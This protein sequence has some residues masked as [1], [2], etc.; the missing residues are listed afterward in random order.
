MS[1]SRT[2]SAKLHF[3]FGCPARLMQSFKSVRE[4]TSHLVLVFTQRPGLDQGP[5]PRMRYIAQ[6]RDTGH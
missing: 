5:V 3:G 2:T 4:S 1:L 6:G